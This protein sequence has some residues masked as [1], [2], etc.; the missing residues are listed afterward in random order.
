MEFKHSK[1]YS[2]VAG[3]PDTNE[4]DVYYQNRDNSEGSGPYMEMKKISD[5]GWD[6][7][8]QKKYIFKLYEKHYVKWSDSC[9]YES[10]GGEGQGETTSSTDEQDP[11]INL[12][13]KG[14]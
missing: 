9:T 14:E 2:P 8:R 13:A 3:Y 11:A 7:E 1:L 10:Q 5:H 4:W 6:K 12:V